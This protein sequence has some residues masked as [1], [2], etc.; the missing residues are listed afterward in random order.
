VTQCKAREGETEQAYGDRLYK[1]AIRAGNVINLGDLTTIFMEGLP[2]SVES[3]IRNWVTPEMSFEKVVRLSQSRNFV[4]TKFPRG[5]YRE[6]QACDGS[7][8]V[9]EPSAQN[10]NCWSVAS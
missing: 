1:A 8:T 2:R 4:S 9:A 3:G 6:A 7:E 10:G 5:S